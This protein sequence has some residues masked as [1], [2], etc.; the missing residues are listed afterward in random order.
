MGRRASR[1]QPLRVEPEN[2]LFA[3]RLQDVISCPK[4]ARVSSRSEHA[5]GFLTCRAFDG[6][7]VPISPKIALTINRGEIATR[8]GKCVAPCRSQPKSPFGDSHVH[9]IRPAAAFRREPDDVLI[10]ILDVAGLAVDTVLRVDD[11]TRLA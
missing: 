6:E 5:Q 8:T 3:R 10:R 11:E 2:G 4:H 9:V 7:P 1:S